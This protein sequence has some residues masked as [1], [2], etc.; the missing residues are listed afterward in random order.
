MNSPQPLGGSTLESYQYVQVSLVQR[1]K[2]GKT[3]HSH[4]NRDFLLQES[5]GFLGSKKNNQDVS[6]TMLIFSLHL[7]CPTFP[8]R[9]FLQPPDDPKAY[10]TFVF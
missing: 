1:E 7:I 2:L 9:K 4:Q 5:L 8:L 3:G 6:S 10:L